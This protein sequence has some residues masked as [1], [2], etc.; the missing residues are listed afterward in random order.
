ML[1][2]LLTNIVVKRV[3]ACAAFSTASIIIIQLVLVAIDSTL[4]VDLFSGAMGIGI[5]VALCVAW[6][7]FVK[8]FLK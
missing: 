3:I 5:A 8:R 7:P 2:E 6:Y 4:V 1:N